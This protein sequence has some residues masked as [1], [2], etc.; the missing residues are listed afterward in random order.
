MELINCSKTKE[1]LVPEKNALS[2]FSLLKEG[3]GKW[4]HFLHDIRS[5]WMEQWIQLV[6]GA[7]RSYDH[8]N[9]SHAFLSQLERLPTGLKTNL[10]KS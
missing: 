1:V 8:L 10:S 7:D 9:S 6:G 4:P 2:P 5:E 3:D